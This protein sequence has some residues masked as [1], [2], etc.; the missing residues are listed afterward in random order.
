MAT[1]TEPR[2]ELAV[3]RSRGLLSIGALWTF[4]AVSVTAIGGLV[5][6]VGAVDLAYDVR[7]G[8]MMLDTH[9]LV[10]ADSFTFT[11]PGR[12][13]V[14]QQWGAQVLFAFVHGHGGWSALL[15]MRAA[16]IAATFWFVYR[17][18]RGVGGGRRVSALL[19]IGSFSASMLA[20]ALRPQLFGFLL[21]S[22]AVWLVVER[23]RH[24]GRLWLLPP[25]VAVWANLHG[26][27][28]LAPLLLALAW[29]DDRRRRAQ[30]S[31]TVLLVGA[32]SV[33]ATLINPFGARVWQYVVDLS[34]NPS[35]TQTI[36]EWQPPTVKNP[37]GA[38]FFLSAALTA[39]FFARRPTPTPWPTLLTL[40]TFFGLGLLAGRGMFWWDL[41]VPSVVAAHLEPKPSVDER[42][43]PLLIAGTIVALLSVLILSLTPPWRARSALAPPSMLRDAPPGITQQ[44]STLLEPGQRV[45]AAQ[46]WASWFELAFP[47]NPVFVDSRIEMF[48]ERLWDEY[49]AVSAGL[50]GWQRV[51][52]RWR[53]DVVVVTPSQQGDLIPRIG[54]D[55]GWRLVYEDGDG[56]IFVPRPTAVD[57]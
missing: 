37:A 40:A 8:S 17:S 14:D 36:T 42:P 18:C 11:V 7:L 55:D 1:R 38:A 33:I 23:D 51:L 27:F 53:V 44:L 4:I 16:M 6:R 54:S 15:I 34:T 22:I 57:P 10:R 31:R 29:V 50:D 46:R 24:P 41:I 25:L 49:Y 28:F 48:P 5:A 9:H 45:F 20:L 30:T 56:A 13:W 47:E 26:S 12:P 21:F 39:A 35:I 32:A 3:G 43:V 2:V 52:E 19:T